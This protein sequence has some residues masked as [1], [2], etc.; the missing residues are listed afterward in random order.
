MGN[1]LRTGLS[2]SCFLIIMGPLICFLSKIVILKCKF[3]SKE[4]PGNLCSKSHI[5][6]INE[7]DLGISV[8]S[9][10]FV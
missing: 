1:W 9:H 7:F 3:M 4:E 10:I 5:C 8:R 2:W 6:S